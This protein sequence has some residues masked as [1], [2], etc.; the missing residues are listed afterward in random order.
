M[1][2][3]PLIG[4][5]SKFSQKTYAEA[6]E[7]IC[8]YY[9]AIGMPRDEFWYGDYSALKDYR[10]AYELKNAQKNQ[11]LYV[12]G[13][14]IFD[15]VTIALSNAFRKKGERSMP[16]LEKPYPLT[17]GKA[18]EVEETEEE[19]EAK[20]EAAKQKIIKDF[21]TWADNW[22]SLYGKGGERK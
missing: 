3:E 22:N 10:K 6:L 18:E 9:M 20:R 5:S 15:G 7:E 1:E 12:L 17:G 11:E 4:F 13:G 19:I 14:Y 21:S 8:S 16:Y 2:D